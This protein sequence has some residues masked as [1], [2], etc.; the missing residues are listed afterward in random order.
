MKS[1]NEGMFSVT[2]SI[3][4]SPLPVVYEETAAA[5][6]AEVRGTTPIGGAGFQADVISKVG[7]GP[8]LLPR[9]N[10]FPC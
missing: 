7:G 8:W 1:A 6:G 9:A 10:L 5:A 4:T 2:K 3:M